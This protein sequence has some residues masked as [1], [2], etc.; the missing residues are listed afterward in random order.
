M[1]ATFLCLRKKLPASCQ[2]VVYLLWVLDKLRLR[3]VNAAKAVGPDCVPP[4]VLKT[5]HEELAPVLCDIFNTCIQHNIFPKQWKEAIVKAVPKKAKPSF[6]ADYRQIS[7]LSCVG[8]V[9]EGILRDAILEDTVT[10]IEP[11]QH[12]F[13]RNRST[14]TALIQILQH[15]LEALNSSPKMDIHAVFVD[16]TQ[17]F[18]TTKHY[19]LLYSLADL[20]VRR[21]LWLIVRSYLSNREQRVKWGSSVSNSFPV[22]AGVPQGGLLSPLL[23]V[24]CINSLDS[25]LPPS[26]IPVKYAD[27]LTITEFLM[28]SLPGLTQ[29]ALDSV[30]EWGQEFTLAMNEGK[31]VDMVIIA[32]RENNIPSPPSSVISGHAINRVSTFK[33]LGVQISSDLSW[34]A[35]V[36]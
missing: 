18:D 31:T 5:F 25:Y 35:H 28:G 6:P 16:F 11:S 4:W 30:V 17:A 36:K 23:F 32:R 14:D 10:K 3:K 29:K 15:W 8:K 34:D 27:D 26:V 13:M 9:F 1:R 33:L 21:P 7:L 20:H 12:S 24:I 22:S 19:Q 2:I